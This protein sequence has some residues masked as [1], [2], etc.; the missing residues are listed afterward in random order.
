MRFETN[1]TKC[2]QN[3]PRY[4]QDLQFWNCAYQRLKIND[5]NF[6]CVNITKK[7]IIAHMK[8]NQSVNEDD[9]NNNCKINV[10]VN[11]K[12]VDKKASE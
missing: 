3:V 5:H 8:E 6:N 11:N 2:P 1:I 12:S 9:R 4:T 10:S 7:T